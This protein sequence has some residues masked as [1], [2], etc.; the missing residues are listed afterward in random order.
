[1][2]MYD[3]ILKKRDKGEL[4]RNEIDFFVQNYT[5]DKIPDYQVS[6]LLMAIYL[7]GMSDEEM[8]N[9]TLAMIES[10]KIMD[11]SKLSGV[12]VDKH[13][14]G[15]VGDK[16]TLIVAPIVAACGIFMA[17]MSGK[18]LGHTGGTIDKLESIPGFKTDIAENNFIKL[19]DSVGAA[20]ISQSGNIVP[21]D[22]KIYALRDVTATIESTSLIAA[23]VMSKKIASGADAIVLDVKTGSGA[24]MKTE[25]E[26]VN[27]AEKM[28]FIG[29]KLN[30][31]VVGLIT[32][33]SEPLG[34]AIGNSLE[35]IE[36]V[37][38]LQNEGPGDLT[39]LC[40]E[41]ASHMVCLA[42]QNSLEECR[43]LVLRSL[44]SGDAF[45]KF[46]EIISSQGGDISY[47]KDVS[48][49]DRAK[50]VFEVL[51]PESGYVRSIDAY[52]CGKASM[53]LGAGRETKEDQ[54]DYSA[55]VVLNAKSGD[56]VAKGSVVAFL[57]TSE[58]QRIKEAKDLILKSIKYSKDMPVKKEIVRKIIY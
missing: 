46:I 51:A 8:L 5:R 14:T 57:H 12:K 42:K 44:R 35:I 23:S 28:V 1:M 45:K 55:G 30:K 37:K 19:V 25:E 29:R 47:L 41:L 56:Y 10:G 9:L 50:F 6:A 36:A 17:K 52:L 54:I 11:L 18:G 53:I 40:V 26:A 39:T 33:M 49:F 15:G 2:R 31:K 13:S 4:T 21:A 58:K 22:K 3:I 34:N 7:N 16:T 43:A 38:V 48:K 27:L 32:D 24:F 20:L